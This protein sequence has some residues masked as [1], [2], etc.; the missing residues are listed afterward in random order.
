VKNPCVGATWAIFDPTDGAKNEG[1]FLKSALGIF[2]NGFEED[3][4]IIDSA[5]LVSAP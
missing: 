2:Q 5:V 3:D 1:C 4:K